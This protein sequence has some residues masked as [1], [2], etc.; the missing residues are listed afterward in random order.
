MEGKQGKK[1]KQCIDK[2]LCILP[3]EKAYYQ[4]KWN[5]DVEY[6]GHPLVEV[7]EAAIAGNQ[8]SVNTQEKKS[9]LYCP[10]AESRKSPR[11]CPLCW[12]YPSHFHSISLL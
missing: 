8:S 3:F 1:M 4:T 5:W 9:S 11:S 10:E 7:I 12:K 2:M 6:V